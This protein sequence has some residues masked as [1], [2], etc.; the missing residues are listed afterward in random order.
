MDPERSTDRSLRR[1]ALLF[2]VLAVAF[3]FSIVASIRVIL[4][5]RHLRPKNPHVFIF[6]VIYQLF[7]LLC[8]YLA[9]RLQKRKL[10][11]IGFRF[12]FGLRDLGSSIGL[13]LGGVISSVFAYVL[14]I[15]LLGR[16]V[17]PSYDHA[18][19]F[20]TSVTVFTWLFAFVNPF[21]EELIVRAYTITEVEGVYQ[22]T[23]LAILASVAVQTSYHLYQGWVGGL[24]HVPAFLLFSWYF[25]RRR[26]I[27]PVVLAHLYMDIWALSSYARHLH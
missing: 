23:V 27:L 11:D 24:S 10:S 20:G 25:V 4:G 16:T 3:L 14:L 18:A 22:S 13:F 6:A 7:G 2:A 26:R 5:V 19:I 17:P 15:F 12:S 9:L 1:Q 21:H 8:L